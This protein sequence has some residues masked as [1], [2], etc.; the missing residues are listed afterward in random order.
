MATYYIRTDGSDANAGT[1]NTSGGAWLTIGKS[2][3]GGIA[4]VTITNTIYVAPGTYRE[5]VT[6]TAAPTA[7][8]SFIADVDASHFDGTINPGKV[9]W[10]SRTTNDRTVPVTGSPLIANSK[11]KFSYDGFIFDGGTSGA[12]IVE[13]LN[14]NTITFSDCVFIAGAPANQNI[15]NITPVVDVNSALLFDRCTFISNASIVI[16]LPTSTVA[17][18]DCGI[19]FKNCRWF[20]GNR[21]VQITASGANS[22]KGGGVQLLNC[23]MFAPFTGG[24]VTSSANVATSIPC[25]AYNCIFVTGGTALNANT[26]GQITENFN[27]IFAI[28]PR[29]NV[30]AGNNSHV[31]EY[32]LHIHLGEEVYQGAQQRP[33]FMPWDSS[34]LLGFGN[35]SGAPTVDWLNRAR[36]EGGGNATNNTTSG[37]ATS[38]AASTLTDSGKSWTT[39]AYAGEIVE[40]TG[41]TGSGQLRAI[42]SNTATALSVNPAWT[43]NPDNTSVYTVYHGGKNPAVGPLE[44][45]DTAIKETSTTQAGSIGLV[46]VGPGSHDFQVPVNAVSTTLSVYVQYDANHSTTNKPQVQLLANG[47]LGVSAETKTVVAGTGTWEQVTFTAFTPSKK[48]K[49]TLRLVSRASNSNGKAFFDTAGGM[50]DIDTTDFAH[51]NRTEPLN[52]LVTIA[53]AGDLPPGAFSLW[54]SYT[55]R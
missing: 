12:Q 52:T 43:T 7:V 13:S 49:V 50:G 27:Y 24:V 29:T 14:G 46:I 8:Q 16:T 4:D 45:H 22:F 41:G 34:P 31:N 44:R 53:G 25:L 23:L 1:S 55:V 54:D 5:S 32:G 3:T 37:T 18:Y 11:N 48:G 9:R 15:I 21:C 30:T 6:M 33:F 39:N 2:L 51:F 20:G 19:V 38:G 35:Q 36:P 40:L 10:S 17:D 28:T 26:S 42:T 47:E